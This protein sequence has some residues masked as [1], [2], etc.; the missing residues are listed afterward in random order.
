[1]DAYMRNILTLERAMYGHFGGMSFDYGWGV[2][3][4]TFAEKSAA[5]QGRQRQAETKCAPSLSTVASSNHTADHM[6]IT[7]ALKSG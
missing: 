7:S 3:R 2:D 4:S 1:M 5:A 6:H